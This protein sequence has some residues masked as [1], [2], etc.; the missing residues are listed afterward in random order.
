METEKK[1]KSHS[2]PND[3]GQSWGWQ[4]DHEKSFTN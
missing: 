3:F 2:K 1:Y 4:G